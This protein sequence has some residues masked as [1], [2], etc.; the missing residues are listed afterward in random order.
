MT[1][2]TQ[3]FAAEYARGVVPAMLK[4]I[5]AAKRDTRLIVAGVL[6]ITYPHQALWLTT[7]EG[8]GPLGWIIPAV[9]DL[10]MLRMLGIVQTTGM[11]P[12]ARTAAL[13]MTGLL[14]TM[15][16][17]VNIAAP[18]AGAARAIF[19]ALVLMAAGVKVVTSLVGPDFTAIE[20]TEAQHIAAA[21][22]TPAGPDPKRSEA[23]RRGA[24]TRRDNAARAATEKAAA[25][26][27]RRQRREDRRAEK[28]ASQA[29]MFAQIATELDPTYQDS[30]APT[31]P[32]PAGT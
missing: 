24:Q 13:V 11:R 16:A 4:T 3:Q 27:A 32:A 10:A 30:T 18:G 31:S 5:T 2:L 25:A 1:T 22:T 20:A 15:S 7:I 29:A 19:G 28:V 26:A 17:A 8:V 12:P 14:A 9:V 6:A 21:Q 23:A